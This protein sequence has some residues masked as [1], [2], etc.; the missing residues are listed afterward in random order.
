MVGFRHNEPTSL[1]WRKPL[2]SLEAVPYAKPELKWVF[3]G[4][5]L[6]PNAAL[7]TGFVV[8]DRDLTL[9]R[10]DKLYTNDSIMT[11]LEELGSADTQVVAIDL[12]KNL[13]ITGKLRQEELKNHFNRMEPNGFDRVAVDRFSSRG[14]HLYNRILSREGLPLLAHS[15][16]LKAAFK[17]FVP[18]RSRSPQ[19]CR[20]LHSAIKETL[21][22]KNMPS[23]LAPSSVLDAMLVAYAGWLSVF[24]AYGEHYSLSEDKEGFVLFEG[25]Q[26]VMRSQYDL[27]NTIRPEWVPL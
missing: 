20:Y 19:G 23:N 27:D 24:G 1:Y 13:A 16:N 2:A 10:M 9:L 18:H 11:V 14:K 22:I 5:D 21:G 6:A 7:E 15:A 17:L 26:P 12:P 4:I 3:V 25:L 8:L